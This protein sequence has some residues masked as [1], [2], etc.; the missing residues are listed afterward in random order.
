MIQTQHQVQQHCIGGIRNWRNE[1]RHALRGINNNSN[2]EFAIVSR[3]RRIYGHKKVTQLSSSL[4]KCA[5][6]QLPWLR[7][8]VR[9]LHGTRR[10]GLSST[11][12]MDTPQTCNKAAKVTTRTLALNTGVR[13][14]C[15][16]DQRRRRGPTCLT[17]PVLG[18]VCC[19]IPGPSSSGETALVNKVWVFPG[20]SG[21]KSA[22]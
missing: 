12:V 11:L 3:S 22:C 4:T 17:T 1:V 9:G 6:A 10:L 5:L 7:L 13:P 8:L 18:S 19:S 21:L 20:G 15:G 16:L 14:A 2:N